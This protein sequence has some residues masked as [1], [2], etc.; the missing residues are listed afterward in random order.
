MVIDKKATALGLVLRLVLGA[1]YAPPVRPNADRI[2]R[3]SSSDLAMILYAVFCPGTT[4]SGAAIFFQ[5]RR[6]EKSFET[7][8]DIRGRK[9][10]KALV[11]VQPISKQRQRRFLFPTARTHEDNSSCPH[12]A[13]RRHVGALLQPGTK[14]RP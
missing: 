14:L 9:L 8:G 5:S 12:Q 11:F 1:N 13:F 4:A 7:F 10:N 2:R 3:L 6:P